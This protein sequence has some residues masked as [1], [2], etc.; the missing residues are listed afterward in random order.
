M[1]NA[2]EHLATT[3]NMYEFERQGDYGMA[4]DSGIDEDKWIRAKLAEKLVMR[5][6]R[7]LNCP[8]QNQDEPEG[9]Y[10]WVIEQ[11]RIGG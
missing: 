7:W 11:R 9:E 4:D 5:T 8:F 2:L 10:K 1:K 6:L 3:F